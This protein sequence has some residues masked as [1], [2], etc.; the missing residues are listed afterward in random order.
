MI[1]NDIELKCTWERIAWF[2]SLLSQFRISATPNQFSAMSEGYLAEIEK[3]RAEVVEYLRQHGASDS[4]Y[5]QY[6]QTK[7][8]A[9]DRELQATQ[10]RIAFFHKIIANIRNKSKTP[11]EYRAFSN[12]YLAEIEKMNAK[13]LEYLKHHPS[14]IEIAEAA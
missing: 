14:E 4:S 2:E 10:E 7:R 12:S 3:M 13:V 1:Q 8:I 9:N 11:E 5:E 6:A